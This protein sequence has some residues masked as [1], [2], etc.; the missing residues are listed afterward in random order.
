M[1]SNDWWLILFWWV[2]KDKTWLLKQKYKYY[3][4]CMSNHDNLLNGKSEMNF[5]LVLQAP[6]WAFQVIVVD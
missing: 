5:S 2:Q 1:V 3:P 6:F 4:H